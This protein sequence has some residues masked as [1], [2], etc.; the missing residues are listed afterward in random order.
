[1]DFEEC[2]NY[3]FDEK[4]LH[5]FD[6]LENKKYSTFHKQSGLEA[7]VTKQGFFI[8]KQKMP[9]DPEEF[10]FAFIKL[11]AEKS[12]EKWDI[13]TQKRKA[14]VFQDLFWQ[15]V[16]KYAIKER[17]KLFLLLE[18]I[19]SEK[20]FDTHA[21]IKNGELVDFKGIDFERGKYTETIIK[22]KGPIIW[23]QNTTPPSLYYYI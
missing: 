11:L 10:T 20:S 15:K 14:E 6:L 8:G 5:Y 9:E 18:H 2:K 12:V 3:T 19:I 21:V 22:E 23:K 16:Q 13:L 1:M 4:I 17:R 7:K